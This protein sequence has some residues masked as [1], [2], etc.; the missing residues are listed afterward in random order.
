MQ[1]P[2]S[3]LHGYKYTIYDRLRKL[4]Y[5]EYEI[6]MTWL[7]NEIGVTKGT[8]RNWIYLKADSATELPATAILKMAT[9]FG[10]EAIEMFTYPFDQEKFSRNW[11]T[12]KLNNN[13]PTILP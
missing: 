6:A 8:F 13:Q 4:P 3:K 12:E 5:E 11:E 2:T 9:F 10:C 7:P 1:K